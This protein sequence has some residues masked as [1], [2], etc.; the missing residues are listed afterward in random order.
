MYLV[1]GAQTIARLRSSSAALYL[2]RRRQPYVYTYIQCVY[3]YI[4]I[5]RERARYMYV[6]IYIERERYI[7]LFSLGLIELGCITPRLAS[8]AAPYLG[9]RC[10]N[11][12]G[13]NPSYDELLAELNTC[14]MIANGN[15]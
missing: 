13:A 1:R 14:Y 12:G 11:H 2:S 5:Y 3:I 7:Q 6:Y 9:W 15:C 8:S 4:Y 10:S